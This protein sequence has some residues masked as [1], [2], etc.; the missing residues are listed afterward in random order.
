[1]QERN[2]IS[3][4][5]TAFLAPLIDGWEKLLLWLLL[6]VVLLL[7]DLKFG[8]AAARNRGEKIRGSR[9]VR[10]TINKLVDYICWLSIAWCLGHTFGESLH[11]PTLAII[12]LAIIY[13][14]ELSSIIDNY[15]EYR[16]IAKRFNLGKFWGL[17]FKKNNLENVLDDKIEKSDDRK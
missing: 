17:I 2:I 14:V 13:S 9:A 1:M 11:I 4:A 6:A 8:I 16:G 15:F 7:A 5:T 12:V 3:G 10:R